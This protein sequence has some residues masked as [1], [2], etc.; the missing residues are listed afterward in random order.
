[1]KLTILKMKNKKMGQNND[2]AQ[3]FQSK[4]GI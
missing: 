2:I 1:M 4:E 3:S